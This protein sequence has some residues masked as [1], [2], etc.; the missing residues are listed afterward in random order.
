VALNIAAACEN[1]NEASLQAL[2]R[3][4]RALWRAQSA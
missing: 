4:W 2:A 1:K 3:R